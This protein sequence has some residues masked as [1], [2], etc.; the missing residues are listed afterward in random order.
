[1][2]AADIALALLLVLNLFFAIRLDN[3]L[4]RLSALQA[5]MSG[6]APVA[7]AQLRDAIGAVGAQVADVTAARVSLDEAIAA[8]RDVRRD[9]QRMA[10]ERAS[11]IA[12]RSE[13]SSHRGL[14]AYAKQTIQSE[15]DMDTPR[16]AVTRDGPASSAPA[17][18][19]DSVVPLPRRSKAEQALEAALRRRR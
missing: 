14:A 3:R 16:M 10:L 9:L 11:E 8:A 4:R 6:I 18:H 5:D 17:W 2:L 15:P 7:E 19:D 1:M 12:A 13:T